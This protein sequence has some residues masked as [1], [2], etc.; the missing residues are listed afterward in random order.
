[1]QSAECRVQ[2]EASGSV[3]PGR[4]EFL[5]VPT[6][7]DGMNDDT[8][9]VTE[10]LIDLFWRHEETLDRLRTLAAQNLDTPAD[11][12]ARLARA[13]TSGRVTQREIHETIEALS[14]A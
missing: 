13:I 10:R 11:L 14:H 1:M 12:K 8:F 7:A 3:L 9:E 5:R 6:P 2:N 4:A